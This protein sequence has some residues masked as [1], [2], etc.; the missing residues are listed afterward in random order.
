MTARERLAA[1]LNEHEGFRATIYDDATG[2]PI[3]PG[4]KVKGH[5]TVGYGLALDVRGLTKRQ[6]AWLRDDMLDELEHDLALRLPLYRTLTEARRMGLLE[7][8]YQCGV[9]GLLGF[10]KA[11]AHLEFREYGAARAEFL[12]SDW[13]RTTG[14]D[15]VEAVLGLICDGLW[16]NEAAA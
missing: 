14:A 2:T 9:D 7:L 3:V 10:K 1:L 11:I 15:R 6:A 5:P 8:A 12:D 4:S 16:P 13:A